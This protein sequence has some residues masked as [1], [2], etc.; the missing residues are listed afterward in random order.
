MGQPVRLMSLLVLSFVGISCQS[1]PPAEEPA[2]LPVPEESAAPPAETAALE[3]QRALSARLAATNE[4]LTVRVR[5]LESLLPGL[6]QQLGLRTQEIR[7]L[8]GRLTAT[9]QQQ[10]DVD[11]ERERLRSEVNSLRQLVSRIEAERDQVQGQLGRERD[12]LSQT[13]DT[14]RNL[15]RTEIARGGLEV[16]HYQD[17]V[18]VNIQENV[19]FDPDSPDLKAGYEHVLRLVARAFADYPDKVIR[20]EGHTAVAPSRW[21]SSWN[22]GAARAVN[23]VRFLQEKAGVSPDRLVAASFGEFRPLAPNTSEAGRARNRRV[24]IVLVDRPLYQ[25]QELLQAGGSQ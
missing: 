2:G 25:V 5:E 8:E 9:T 16:L 3:E 24:Q 22:L 7:D 12:R 1:L 6:N 13:A 21:D 17:V 15:L 18:V 19:A 4:G 10:R 20:V 14:L 23:V 11:L